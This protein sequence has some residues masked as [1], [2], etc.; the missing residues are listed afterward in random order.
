MRSMTQIRAVLL[1]IYRTVIAADFDAALG[2]LAAASGLERTD[3][4]VGMQTHAEALT[5]GTITLEQAFADTFELAGH[6]ALDTR[7]LV[8]RDG[9]ILYEHA[10]VYPDVVPFLVEVRRRGVRTALVSNCFANTTELLRQCGL[11]DL[12]DQAILSCDVGS[13][14]PDPAIFRAALGSLD[15]APEQ[16]IFVDDRAANCDVAEALGMAAVLI[17]RDN[18][19]AGVAYTLEEV[20]PLL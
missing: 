4:I 18:K 5:I 9:E 10:V 11:T 8:Q 6:D 20:L 14:K 17:D 7:L 19:A 16:A 1:D 2:E 3:W 13:A 15:V 12:I